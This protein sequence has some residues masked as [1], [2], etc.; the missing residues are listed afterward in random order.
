MKNYDREWHV[1]RHWDDNGEGLCRPKNSLY[2]KH[3]LTK[4][5]AALSCAKCFRIKF[6]KWPNRN[7]YFK[8]PI[9]RSNK[10][11]VS[12]VGGG[13]TESQSKARR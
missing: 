10:A 4:E 13:G 9:K 7:G 2:Q 5:I 11:K 1:K 3:E 12:R 8:Q 6:G